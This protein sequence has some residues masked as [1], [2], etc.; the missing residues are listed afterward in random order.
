MEFFANKTSFHKYWSAKFC[1]SPQTRRQVSAYVFKY[2]YS[3]PQQP[4]ANRG[5]FGS[6]SL[7]EKRQ[8][9]RSDKDVEILDDK[10]ESRAEGGRRFQMEGP[11]TE[12]N[13]FTV[14]V[15]LPSFPSTV[16][17]IQSINWRK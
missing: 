5:A 4:W 10:K 6:D 11:P 7:Q 9:L 3:A 2:L 17:K 13:I 14:S 16:H 15:I 12:K 8:V 1:P